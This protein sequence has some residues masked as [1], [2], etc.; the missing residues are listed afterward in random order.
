METVSL[1]GRLSTTLNLMPQ[2]PAPIF[3]STR[4]SGQEQANLILTY[5]LPLSLR[6]LVFVSNEANYSMPISE[7]GVQQ[8]F[9]DSLEWEVLV[10]PV[11]TN[12]NGKE[13]LIRTT[14]GNYLTSWDSI[15]NLSL[16]PPT[17]VQ[18]QDASIP[19]SNIL[20]WWIN[21]RIPLVGVQMRRKIINRWKSDKN[22]LTALDFDG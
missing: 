10:S 9:G 6:R 7:T 22:H 2:V 19:A 14:Y 13:K 11:G 12:G 5:F 1:R 15:T 17:L 20:M 16:L 4:C 8:A 3:L 21:L 18:P